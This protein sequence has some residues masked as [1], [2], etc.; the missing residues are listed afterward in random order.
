MLS[1][2]GS[3]LFPGSDEASSPWRD[4]A[5]IPAIAEADVF[6]V[7]MESPLGQMP[8]GLSSAQAEMNLCADPAA[9]ALLIR[10]NVDLV[11]VANN[12]GHD[13]AQDPNLNTTALL[14]AEGIRS[15]PHLS[16]EYIPTPAGEQIA[17][18]ALND[19][20]DFYDLENLK[21]QIQSARGRSGLVVVSLHWGMEYQGGPTPRQEQ[22]SREL[23]DAGADVLWG[24]H[25]HVL[26]RVEWITSALDGHRALVLYSLGNLLS[27][28]FMSEDTLRT[29]LV[30]LDFHDHQVYEITVFPLVMQREAM[31]VGFPRDAVSVD[32]ITDRLQLD[33][34][35]DSGVR[36]TVWRPDPD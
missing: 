27:D 16:V 7:N 22:L 29:A 3:M 34:L 23:V 17:F 28:Q 4:V 35:Y 9:A 14:S 32:R 6:A 25:P 33:E 30:R 19:Y 20:S 2:A 11:T 12:H 31:K 13:C 1:R 26:Q 8:A 10:M 18:I 36:I 21:Q 15:V 5:G 24:H